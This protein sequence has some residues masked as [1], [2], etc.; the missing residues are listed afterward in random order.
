MTQD[1]T[2]PY[3]HLYHY[4]HTINTTTITQYAYFA[5]DRCFIEPRELHRTYY[6]GTEVIG[7]VG[8]VQPFRSELSDCLPRIGPDGV[9][10]TTSDIL[11]LQG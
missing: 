9:P 6:L 4:H 8:T 5:F 10:L 7:F 3:N 2:S 1:S 11:L